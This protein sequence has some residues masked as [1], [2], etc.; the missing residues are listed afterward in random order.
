MVAWLQCPISIHILWNHGYVFGCY[1]LPLAGGGAGR[2]HR[3]WW[4]DGQNN[5]F[6]MRR[7][8]S[9]LIR[10]NFLWPLRKRLWK[11][12]A[13]LWTSQSRRREVST[14]FDFL[15][16]QQQRMRGSGIV[17]KACVTYWTAESRMRWLVCLGK[18]VPELQKRCWVNWGSGGGA[19]LW[20]N[21]DKW[22]KDGSGGSRNMWGSAAMEPSQELIPDDSAVQIWYRSHCGHVTAPAR[23]DT[24]HDV[25]LCQLLSSC[26]KTDGKDK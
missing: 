19:G 25:S 7:E 23:L 4:G 18:E 12:E 10:N 3:G 21:C 13:K 14:T 22:V 17:Y 2:R 16:C 9:G 26:W 20:Q 6:Q 24:A 5:G 8:G 1:S 11:R 15:C